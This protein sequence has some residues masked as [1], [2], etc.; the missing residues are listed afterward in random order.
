MFI[1]NITFFAGLLAFCLVSKG[2]NAGTEVSC[3]HTGCDHETSE[4]EAVKDIL[5]K[6]C[7]LNDIN[8][9]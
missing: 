4:L 9:Q 6:S 1:L 7:S 3:S 2:H 8:P 5:L